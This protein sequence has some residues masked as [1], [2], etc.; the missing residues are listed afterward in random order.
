MRLINSVRR[1]APPSA[2]AFWL[3]F[4]STTTALGVS[5]LAGWQRGGLLAERIAWIAIGAVLVVSAHVL[6]ALC[7]TAPAAVRVVG[8]GLWVVCMVTTCYGHAIFFVLAQEHA[9][10]MR[11][12]ALPPAVVP[13]APVNLP[14]V[15]SL[16]T[17]AAERQGCQ[18]NRLTPPSRSG[19]P[20]K[21]V[22][23]VWV[24]GLAISMN[25]LHAQQVY[26]QGEHLAW[27]SVQRST[28]QHGSACTRTSTRST[29]TTT[30]Q[31]AAIAMKTAYAFARAVSMVMCSH[32]RTAVFASRQA[33]V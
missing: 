19:V 3:A 21:T 6:P 2:C 28:S 22:K 1:R 26:L 32:G 10:A 11:V 27:V 8:T 12:G 33:F 13:T 15:R 5:V 18:G 20:M 7:R 30:S 17:I 23:A 14:P 24:I 31:W 9:A 16:T 25:S 4:A 29:S